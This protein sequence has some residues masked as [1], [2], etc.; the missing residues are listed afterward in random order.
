MDRLL[1]D[2]YAVGVDMVACTACGVWISYG[3][4]DITLCRPC[5]RIRRMWGL[6]LFSFRVPLLLDS[7]VGLLSYALES[8]MPWIGNR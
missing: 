6:V 5:F 7:S 8:R 4:G 3:V 2:A 1:L